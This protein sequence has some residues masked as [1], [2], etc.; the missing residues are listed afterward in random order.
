VLNPKP[1]TKPVCRDADDDWILAA[2]LEAKA[3]IIVTGD[4]DLLVLQSFQN[5]G[6]IKPNEFWSLEKSKD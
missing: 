6:I 2:A 3:D 1:L 4:N 5:I